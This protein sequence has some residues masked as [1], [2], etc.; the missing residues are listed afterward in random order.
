VDHDAHRRIDGQA[1]PIHDGMRHPDRLDAERAHLDAIA[2]SH[3]PQISA[4]GQ[5]VLAQLVGHQRQRHRRAVD[6]HLG[7]PQQIG[8][9]PD[10]VLVAVGEEEGAEA[11]ALGQR[12]GKI[13]NDVV[14]AGHLVGIRE[15]EPAVHGDQV[16]AELD[17]HHV[18]ADLAEAAQGYE[19]D[20]RLGQRFHRDSFRSRDTW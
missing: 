6:G 17:Q 15:H 20:G 12:V 11:L 3:R 2:G 13:G 18:E 7:L 19:A 16:V 10:V 8:H 5:A 4:L 9:R 14:D 1:D